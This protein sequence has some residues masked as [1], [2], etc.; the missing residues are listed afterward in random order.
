MIQCSAVG[1]RVALSAA[2]VVIQ[3]GCLADPPVFI[4]K[5]RIPPLIFLGEVSP[6]VGEIYN[7]SIPFELLVPFRSEDLNQ[8]LEAR[9]FLNLPVDGQPIPADLQFGVLAGHWE[10]TIRSVSMLWEGP[11]QGCNSLTLVLSSQQS[12]PAIG[13]PSPEAQAARVVWWLNTADEQGEVR[14]DSCGR[15]AIGSAP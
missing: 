11:L 2:I 13:L 15:S 8:G 1:I 3:I 10:D 7:G 5:D 12:F 4:G 9:L 14:V 6:P